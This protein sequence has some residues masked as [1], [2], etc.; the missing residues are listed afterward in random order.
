MSKDDQRCGRTRAEFTRPHYHT[1]AGIVRDYLT[2]HFWPHHVITHEVTDDGRDAF[3][4]RDRAG[5]RAVH[6]LI[7]DVLV[8]NV[9][10]GRL[11]K[12]ADFLA[13]LQVA[14]HLRTV[15]AVPLRLTDRGEL[16]EVDSGRLIAVPPVRGAGDGQKPAARRA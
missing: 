11:H 15:G 14:H 8:L 9:H 3:C 1:T 16:R 12:L 5:R 13:V 7:V 2:V 6:T 4:V 10:E